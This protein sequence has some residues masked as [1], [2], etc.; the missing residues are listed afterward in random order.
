MINQTKALNSI[1]VY[2]YVCEKYEQVLKWHCERFTN[3]NQP[4]FTD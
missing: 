2:Q 1:K 3:N 4:D